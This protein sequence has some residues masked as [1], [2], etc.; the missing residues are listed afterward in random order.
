MTT[1]KNNTE[2]VS[3]HDERGSGEGQQYQSHLIPRDQVTCTGHPGWLDG[4]LTLAL[5]LN[6]YGQLAVLSRS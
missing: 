2:V 6:H 3:D 5:A 1:G 4:N